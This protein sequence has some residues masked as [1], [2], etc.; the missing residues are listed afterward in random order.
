MKKTNILILAYLPFFLNDFFNIYVT[1][2]PAWVILD[3]AVRLAIIIF[4]FIM[5][6]RGD[7]TR[8]D[9][10]LKFPATK[11]FILW[12]VGTVAVSMAF[13]Y[14]TE[15]VFAPY[16]PKGSVGSVPIDIDSPLFLFDSTIGLV[17]VGF[18]EE[19]VCRSLT[20][21]ALKDKLSTPQLYIVSAGLFS[22]MHWSLSTHTL[23]DA[24]IYGLIFVPATLATA[25]IW[26]AV[27]THF[28]VNFVL[29]NM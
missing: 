28:L 7:L 29:Y 21:S 9:L 15:F 22:L 8:N 2:Y 6:S 20:F 14:L 3:Y 24:F 13:L 10:Y 27:V 16:Y 17:L 1:G 25:S 12:T 11:D 23:F 26:P 18:S 5:L 19:L 4:L